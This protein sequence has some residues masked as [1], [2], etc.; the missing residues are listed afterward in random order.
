MKGAH[1]EGNCKINEGSTCINNK[2]NKRRM[3]SY[4]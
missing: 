3:V 1:I 2:S 4:L